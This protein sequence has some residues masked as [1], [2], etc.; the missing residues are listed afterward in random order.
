M[1]G[2]YELNGL[3]V[4]EMDTSRNRRGVID[5]GK[6]KEQAGL[7]TFDIGINQPSP[8]ATMSEAQKSHPAFKERV[9]YY[10]NH[11]PNSAHGGK[12]QPAWSETVKVKWAQQMTA[13]EVQSGK[14][15]LSEGT[16]SKKS[17]WLLPVA[18]VAGALLLYMG[19]N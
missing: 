1:L 15:V 2:K 11:L 8:L 7:P 6:I 9:D 17:K 5:W 3:G 12:G 4:D 19:M 13:R 16:S 10:L 14:L 18:G